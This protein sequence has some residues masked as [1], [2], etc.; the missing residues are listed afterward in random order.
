[1]LAVEMQW[2]LFHPDICTSFVKKDRFTLK[3]PL[4]FPLRLHLVV[5]SERTKS[6]CSKPHIDPGVI[7]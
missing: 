2:S 1:M 4:W 7:F 5:T 3:D 6:D